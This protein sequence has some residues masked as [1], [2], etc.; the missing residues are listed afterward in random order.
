M[1]ENL[2]IDF[3]ESD[4]DLIK[5]FLLLIK[6]FK[7]I[8]L[9]SL[10]STAITFGYLISIS[11]TYKSKLTVSENELFSFLVE[12]NTNN[13]INKLNFNSSILFA[14]QN[15]IFLNFDDF[16]LGY[17]NLDENIKLKINEMDLF[18]SL[19]I[20]DQDNSKILDQD[21]SSFNS[22]TYVLTSSLDSKFSE[23]A[24]K[25]LVL[26]SQTVL[27]NR[28]I[29]ILER[30]I[31]QTVN[32]ID[33][34]RK[35]KVDEV[36]EQKLL[37]EFEASKIENLSSSIISNEIK[38]LKNNYEIAKSMG[39]ID[40]IFNT[41]ELIIQI[42][43]DF[44]N[45]NTSRISKLSSNGKNYNEDLLNETNRYFYGTKIL[46]QQIRVLEKEMNRKI[47]YINP[48]LANEIEFIDSQTSDEFILDLRRTKNDLKMFQEAKINLNELN[49]LSKKSSFITTFNINRISSDRIDR[50]DISTYIIA[51]IL[52]TII[53]C[54]YVIINYIINRRL[55]DENELEL[56][57][58]VK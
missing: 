16:V 52:G 44:N 17:K 40:P 29:S 51:L 8:I 56:I 50:S 24:L 57:N 38:N 39:Y 43:K 4:L 14:M 46:S 37:L 22:A 7:K 6:N 41:N 58:I 36:R 19:E 30:K 28:L 42:N 25:V 11:I 26:N 1:S 13:A 15:E 33:N 27:F 20:L 2:K 53:G 12:E 21:N 55:S 31:L 9:F 32:I 23:E 48:E 45:S 47:N 49:N 5:Y 18:D 3:K 10:I 35:D 34:K 54:A